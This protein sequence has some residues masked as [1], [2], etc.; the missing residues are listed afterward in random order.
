MQHDVELPQS[1]V[2]TRLMVEYVLHKLHYYS[3]RVEILLGGWGWGWRG[4]GARDW[5][6]ARGINGGWRT[7]RRTLIG[8]RLSEIWREALPLARALAPTDLQSD[9]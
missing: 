7:K 2:S 1:F 4:S 8:W 3:Q 6:F 5:L 9:Q